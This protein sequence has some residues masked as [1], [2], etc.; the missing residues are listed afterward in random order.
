MSKAKVVLLDIFLLQKNNKNETM[1]LLGFMMWIRLIKGLLFAQH[2]RFWTQ[3]NKQMQ[4]KP[5]F[6]RALP[7]FY[8]A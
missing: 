1:N 6:L 3:I 2:L 8:A 4:A 7:H 5:P